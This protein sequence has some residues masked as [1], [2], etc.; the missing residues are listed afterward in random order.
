MFAAYLYRSNVLSLQSYRVSPLLLS[1]S[2]RFLAPLLGD[3]VVP[4]RSNAAAHGELPAT[5]ALGALSTTAFGPTTPR[6]RP[7]PPSNTGTPPR[8]QLRSRNPPVPTPVAPGLVSQWTQ[9]ITGGSSS[10][11]QPS[12]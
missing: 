7:A 9:G 2:K 6:N 8:G 12:E 1:L 5:S 3:G 11:R 10:N 4:R